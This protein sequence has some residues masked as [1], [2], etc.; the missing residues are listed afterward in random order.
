M[1]G[2]TAKKRV[3]KA[4]AGPR[5]RKNG[6][7][8]EFVAEAERLGAL[9]AVVIDPRTVVTGTWVGVKCRYGC[10]GY[11]TSLC[12]PPHSLAPDQT[13]RLLDE[14][15]RGILF[16]GPMGECKRIAVELERHIFLADY[17]KA[18]GLGAG[19]CSLCRE[20]CAF[21][22]GCRHPDRARPA[23]EA[24]GIDVFSTARAREFEI[25]VVKTTDEKG[26]YFGLVLVE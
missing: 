2:K 23:M 10:G 18:F 12:C 20:P 1:A 7:L 13:R 4:S 15:R 25:H 24:C 8:A 11:G 17:P 19:P 16:E 3:K 6:D 21:D 22:E 26:H 9:R 14:Y 5:G